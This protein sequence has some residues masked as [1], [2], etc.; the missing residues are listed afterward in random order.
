[1]AAEIIS[2]CEGYELPAKFNCVHAVFNCDGKFEDVFEGATIKKEV[3]SRFQVVGNRLVHV[4]DDLSALVITHVDR[5]D[6]SCSQKTKK[7]FRIYG[8][9]VQQF[10]SGL[11]TQGISKALQNRKKVN[12]I[13]MELLSS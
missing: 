7:I 3:E 2:H 1:V 5:H 11:A 10:T 12:P 13:G 6:L 4:V 9:G 8:C